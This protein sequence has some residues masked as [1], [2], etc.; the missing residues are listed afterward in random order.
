MTLPTRIAAIQARHDEANA[1]TA[2]GEWHK[3]RH[4]LAH[5]DRAELLA[6]VKGLVGAL[7]D[8]ADNGTY[9]TPAGTTNCR[10]CDNCMDHEGTFRNMHADDCLINKARAL[11]DGKDE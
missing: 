9:G 1:M 7:R 8:L 4:N 10:Y 11:L 3:R 2:R 6:I 5:T